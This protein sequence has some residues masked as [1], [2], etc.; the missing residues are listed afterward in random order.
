MGS[1]VAQYIYQKQ[2]EY[3]N[4]KCKVFA[5]QE[6]LIEINDTE[7]ERG[8]RKLSSNEPKDVQYVNSEY[9]KNA[10]RIL[11]VRREGKIHCIKELSISV[12]I[13]LN[14]VD[15]YLNADNSRVI[16][17]DT[18]KNT[19][20]AL[21][22]CN[23]I[24][25]I[26]EFGLDICKHFIKTFCHVVYC[27]AFI[28]EVP[29]QRLEKDCT[30][31]AHAFLY[32]SEGIR[33][34]EVEQTQDS[35]PIVFSGIKD[36]KLMKTTQSGFQG[37]LKEKYTTLPERIDRVLSVETLIKWCY[38][39][40]LDGLDY[41][42]IWRTA[43]ESVLDAFAGPPETGHYSPSYQKTVNCIQTFILERI[44][45]IEEVEVILSNIH[46]SVTNLEKLGLSNDKEIFTPQETPF[47]ACAST[48]RRKDCSKKL[49]N[50][51]V[52]CKPRCS[53]G[54]KIGRG[55]H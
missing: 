36:L 45:Q 8:G 40:C 53:F 20:E 48:L 28:Q 21:A 33:F 22:K 1:R 50:M 12:H 10:V 37:F 17:T 25:T 31:H 46:Y 34:C 32:S 27:N 4:I 42:C 19:I 13:R 5:F 24:R 14:T 43:H 30:P 39:E 55:L 41:D 2:S 29:W 7:E 54:W 49:R 47:G 6:L 38:G 9:G 26:E 15:E 51:P 11:Y 16:P 44:P 18:I 23:G 52:D 35:A 3:D